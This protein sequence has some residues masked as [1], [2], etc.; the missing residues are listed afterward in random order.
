MF[1]PAAES[2]PLDEARLAAYLAGIGLPLD[3]SEP[4]RQFGTGLAN[5]NYRLTAGGRRLVL[6]RPPGG[7]LPPGAHDMS[8]EHRILSRLW[9]VHP[10]AP[11]S[12]HLCEDRS[13]IGVPFQLIDYR[14]GLVIK[15][16]FRISVDNTETL[17]EE[18]DSF[19]F[20]SE[21]PHWV[22]NERDDVSVLM[23]IMVRSNPLHQI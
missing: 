6:R 5:I 1:R 19:Q 9:R 22:K 21:L 3:T 17:I 16:T 2:A 10:L 20:D 15:G 14:P 4:V 11:E 8:R 12:L 23:W 18:G 13:V 7:D